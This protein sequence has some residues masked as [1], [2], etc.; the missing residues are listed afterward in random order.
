MQMSA[1]WQRRT[2]TWAAAAALLM[3]C[4]SYPLAAN[5]PA[6]LASGGVALV[7][8]GFPPEELAQVFIGRDELD[9][10]DGAHV[11]WVMVVPELD[12]PPVDPVAATGPALQALG[13]ENALASLNPKASPST[14]NSRLALRASDSLVV[15]DNL[16]RLTTVD[17]QTFVWPF[18]AV[19][20]EGF[21]PPSPGGIFWPSIGAS[22]GVFPIGTSGTFG[23][24]VDGP[25]DLSF[26]YNLSLRETPEL[27]CTAVGPLRGVIVGDENVAGVR[28][29][30]T[31]VYDL[32]GTNVAE[33]T[34]DRTPSGLPPETYRGGW[35]DE[36]VP[37]PSDRGQ[38]PP[39]DLGES[40]LALRSVTT[41]RQLVIEHSTVDFSIEEACPSAA[42]E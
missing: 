9:L 39:P 20:A 40:F 32:D 7:D 28:H 36:V 12:N 5:G 22:D 2:R 30:L 38:L 11:Q 6:T 23:T 4:D 15:G 25:P 33:I 34:I 41:G 19:V 24:L 21:Q 35:V 18:E 14:A 1:T 8:L 16:I 3:G 31:G 27:R 10:N 26:R 42:D 29:E 17:G 37:A 13:A